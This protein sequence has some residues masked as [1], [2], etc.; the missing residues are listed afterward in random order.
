MKKA[1]RGAIDL[2]G[3]SLPLSGKTSNIVFQK[4]GR[5]RIAKLS[6]GKRKKKK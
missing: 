6:S 4:N 5:I 1:S 2:S 3:L